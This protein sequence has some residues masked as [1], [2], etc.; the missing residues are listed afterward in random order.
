M[1]MEICLVES[2]QQMLFFIFDQSV[3]DLN[4]SSS[5]NLASNSAPRAMVVHAKDDTVRQT[6]LFNERGKSRPN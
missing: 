2:K 6:N 4:R 3:M 1:Q 5:N